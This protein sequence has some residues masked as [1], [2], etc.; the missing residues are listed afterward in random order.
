MTT[1]TLSKNTTRTLA[2]PSLTAWIYGL[3]VAFAASPLALRTAELTG[4]RNMD[5]TLVVS[6]IIV[7]ALIAGIIVTQR[8]MEEA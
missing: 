8:S 7:G 3:V 1:T 4:A 5:A 6:A 2:L